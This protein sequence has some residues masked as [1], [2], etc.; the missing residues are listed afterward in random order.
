VRYE[1]L[2]KKEKKQIRNKR[3]KRNYVVLTRHCFEVV[4]AGE[5]N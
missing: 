1:R 5:R 3:N 4:H 2:K